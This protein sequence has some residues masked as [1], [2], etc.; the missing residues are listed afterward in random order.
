MDNIS[1]NLG[2]ILKSRFENSQS[3]YPITITVDELVIDFQRYSGHVNEVARGYIQGF[4]DILSIIGGSHKEDQTI[5]I[6]NDR[7]AATALSLCWSIHE[8]TAPLYDYRTSR[9]IRQ[10]G[11]G[12]D[13]LYGLEQKRK[14]KDK[15]GIRPYSRTQDVVIIIVKAKF[16]KKP[17]ILFQYDDRRN[18]YKFIGGRKRPTE[19]PDS[20]AN[21]ELPHE[22]IVCLNPDLEKYA[23]IGREYS[24]Y[25]LSAEPLEYG[26][27]STMIGAY[28]HYLI[29][30]YE[31]NIKLPDEAL[32]KQFLGEQK[33]KTKWIEL[34]KVTPDNK[35]I[36]YSGLIN[37][38]RSPN[39]DLL[40]KAR[41][42][43]DQEICSLGLIEWFW[44][45]PRIQ[46]FFFLAGI[47]T[48]IG[49]L[50]AIYQLFF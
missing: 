10:E 32:K 18:G 40:H 7:Q 1:L 43:T 27:I 50:I 2:E 23:Q 28:T 4:F 15:N 39:N 17:Y 30:V 29:H 19:S 36:I 24:T 3:N 45:M 9:S 47:A 37:K 26:E 41:F 8:K 34:E 49:T 48:L 38:L 44:C 20:T 5:T 16:R 33:R 31:C 11:F 46:K 25:K 21:R 12:A 13:F 35:F 14:N 42:S 22:V 6:E